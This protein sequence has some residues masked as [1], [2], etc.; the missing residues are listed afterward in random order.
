MSVSRALS[1]T[2]IYHNLSLWMEVE[3]GR[4]LDLLFH[5]S[6]RTSPPVSVFLPLSLGLSLTC[7][8]KD[9]GKF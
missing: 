3:I 9:C 7:S 5:V 6:I 4:V 8:N 2:A 1:S